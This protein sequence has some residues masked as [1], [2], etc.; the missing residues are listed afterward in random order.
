M[1]RRWV[2]NLHALLQAIERHNHATGDKYIVLIES[3][4]NAKG[5]IATKLAVG[6][7]HK[8]IC[9]TKLPVEVIELIIENYIS[10]T[11]VVEPNPLNSA[12][13]SYLHPETSRRL[14]SLRLLSKSWNAAAVPFI[15]NA[16]YLNTPRK[17]S[18]LLRS[19]NNPSQFSTFHALRRICFSGLLFLSNYPTGRSLNNPSTY[20][21][22]NA[23]S[24][25]TLLA[26]SEIAMDSALK[27]INLCSQNLSDLK[28]KFVHSIGLSQD[29]LEAISNVK[30][31][32]VLGIVGSK[33]CHTLNDSGSIRAML[34]SAFAL[35]SLS[36]QCSS[37]GSLNLN[38]GAL[39]NLTH[40]CLVTN[41]DNILDF[42]EL[43]TAEGRKIWFL[44][45]ISPGA[46]DQC[47]P[48]IMALKG[49]LQAVF[50]DPIP[51]RIPRAV[52]NLTFENLRVVRCMTC[53][54]SLSGYAWLQKPIF[55]NMEVLITSY[56]HANAYWKRLLELFQHR[57]ITLPPKFKQIFLINS[58]GQELQDH[59]MVEAF[60]TQGVKTW[61]M[62]LESVLRGMW[63]LGHPLGVLGYAKDSVY[64][65][66]HCL[67]NSYV[68]C[69]LDE[70][71][72]FR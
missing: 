31:L 12:S 59:G 58:K 45:L 1:Y 38:V 60:K 13:R 65:V 70:L 3:H 33:C 17:S 64:P 48:I 68:V 49:S 23:H 24:A 62:G 25:E 27:I 37:L 18:I 36:I 40:L 71:G 32:K 26:P 4:P 15:Y 22:G 30:G 61:Q 29:M 72:G 6:Q 66:G 43:C 28:L 63:G 10:D 54:L 44:E 34:N 8:I 51:A 35:E 9:S 14:L 39:P 20:E 52:I 7:I 55:K 56:W 5:L 16:L 57:P 67:T 46:C 41:S 21:N 53:D 69:S 19:W 11:G 42:I 47:H 50:I 2:P